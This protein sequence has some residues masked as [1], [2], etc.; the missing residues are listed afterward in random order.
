MIFVVHVVSMVFYVDLIGEQS[1]DDPQAKDDDKHCTDELKNQFDSAEMESLTSYN[2]V[3]VIVIARGQ[4][5]MA[6]N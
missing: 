5:F 4:G 2:E 6:V 1:S 3:D